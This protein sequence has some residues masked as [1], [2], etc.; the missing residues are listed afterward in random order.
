MV[1]VSTVNQDKTLEEEKVKEGKRES[2][3]GPPSGRGRRME[4]KAE[5]AGKEDEEEE[6][7]EET[8]WMDGGIREIRRGMTTETRQM[9]SDGTL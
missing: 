5:A 4:G 7:E 1:V 6:Q 9:A 8:K 2:G 3:I